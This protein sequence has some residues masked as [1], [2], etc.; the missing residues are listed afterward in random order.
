MDVRQILNVAGDLL[1]TAGMIAA[2]LWVYRSKPGTRFR[3][4]REIEPDEE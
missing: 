4:T 1:L 2:V 3:R